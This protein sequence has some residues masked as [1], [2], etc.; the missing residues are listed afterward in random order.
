MLTSDFIIDIAVAAVANKRRGRNGKNT[1]R[2]GCQV[3]KQS[4]VLYSYGHFKDINHAAYLFFGF[5]VLLLSGC[6][7]RNKLRNRH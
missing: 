4:A 7:T 3:C 6:L 2:V 1:R 5:A